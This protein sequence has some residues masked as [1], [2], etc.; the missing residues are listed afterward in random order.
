ME[1]GTYL[2]LLEQSQGWRIFSFDASLA[3][4]TVCTAIYTY[5]LFSITDFI[6]PG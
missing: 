2:L 1:K 5:L 6:E 4:C 3:S